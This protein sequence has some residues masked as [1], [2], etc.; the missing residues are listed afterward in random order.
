MELR[1]AGNANLAA[2]QPLRIERDIR[3]SAWII[4]RRLQTYQQ[5]GFVMISVVRVG[6]VLHPFRMRPLDRAGG[7]SRRKLPMKFRRLAGISGIGPVD[8]PAFFQNEVYAELDLPSG[9]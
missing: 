9:S 4:R 5:Q 2:D 1:V 3:G 6:A 7:E 8:V